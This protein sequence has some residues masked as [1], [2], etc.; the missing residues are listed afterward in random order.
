MK[1]NPWNIGTPFIPAY[2]VLSATVSFSITPDE[3]A[4]LIQRS[5]R[6]TL[7]Y[8]H[9]MASQA[10]SPRFNYRKIRQTELDQKLFAFVER[11]EKVYL[12][13]EEPREEAKINNLSP[14]VTNINGTH[15][16]LLKKDTNI[17][18]ILGL[19]HARKIIF[20]KKLEKVKLPKK[21]V[22]RDRSKATVAFK[23]EPFDT[24]SSKDYTIYAERIEPSDRPM[25]LEE[26]MEITI[27]F[28]HAK[29]CDFAPGNLLIAE[30]GIYFVDT[31]DKSFSHYRGDH[32]FSLLETLA[33]HQMTDE[34][35]SWLNSHIESLR[36]DKRPWEAPLM[37]SD[38]DAL[39][40]LKHKRSEP[41]SSTHEFKVSQ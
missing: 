36:S 3:A 24:L 19:E 23:I 4:G 40:R 21:Y 26:L 1:L 38:E 27:F 41:I 37:K 8:R 9:Q 17:T 25:S 30:D 11:L 2:L 34:A 22:W 39:N 12:L 32:H 5:Y 16:R 7:S 14:A 15:V 6:R 33:R 20:K 10:V 13:A 29:F 35:A 31:E 28:H 18:R